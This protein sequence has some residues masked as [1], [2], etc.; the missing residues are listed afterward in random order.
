MK[1]LLSLFGLKPLVIAAAFAA[2]VSASA[3]VPSQLQPPAGN[4]ETQR[5]HGEGV[6]IYISAPNPSVPGQFVWT[7]V[8]P[9]ATLTNG[10]GHVIGHHFGGPTWQ[11][12]NTGSL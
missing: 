5:L 8:A 3:Q 1:N 4:V 7:F 6:Q 10:G 2:V 9:R 12:D 11:A